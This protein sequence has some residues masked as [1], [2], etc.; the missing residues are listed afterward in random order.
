MNEGSRGLRKLRPERRHDVRRGE[1]SRIATHGSDLAHERGGDGAN[2][3]RGW[4][5]NGEHIWRHGLIHASHLH[6][7]VEISA[8]TQATNQ[9]RG[10]MP[11]RGEHDQIIEGDNL[12]TGACRLR[13][14]ICN[15]AYHFS[16]CL[17]IEERHFRRLRPDT[18]N[19]AVGQ[20]TSVPQDIDMPV[21]Q[22]IE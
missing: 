21:C 16:P 18:D 13:Q 4:Q 7:I 14:R 1:G 19:Q 11:A 8:V 5:E 10:A 22:R 3:C 17:D 12:E 6:F 2:Q 9:D 20:S 15:F